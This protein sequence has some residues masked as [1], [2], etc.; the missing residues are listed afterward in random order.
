[1]LVILVL[2]GVYLWSGLLCLFEAFFTTREGEHNFTFIFF[3]FFYFFGV[4]ILC[5][6]GL[7]P[8]LNFIKG[9]G[10]L[11]R[12]TPIFWNKLL[13]QTCSCSLLAKCSYGWCGSSCGLP[14]RNKDWWF[15][16][17]RLVIS[18]GIYPLSS[19]SPSLVLLFSLTFSCCHSPQNP[20]SSSSISSPIFPTPTNHT[21][22]SFRVFFNHNWS[23]IQSVSPSHT[24][25][26]KF[27]ESSKKPSL[28]LKLHQNPSHFIYTCWTPL[29]VPLIIL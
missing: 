19:S 22:H 2:Y 27:Q 8:I 26:R 4:S 10:G 11:F 14:T 21:S 28:N 3:S 29:N 13:K 25:P 12:S 17:K 6:Q 20:F 18:P 7:S 9:K 1:M 15:P 16:L 24:K 23:S 5:N